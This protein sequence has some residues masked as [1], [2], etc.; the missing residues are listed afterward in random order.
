MRPPS[1]SRVL[2]VAK[3]EARTDADPETVTDL[4]RLWGACRRPRVPQGADAGTA[5][6]EPGVAS[7]DRPGLAVVQLQL[8]PP[9]GDDTERVARLRRDHRAA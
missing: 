3:P 8:H 1:F 6:P 9:A 7:E 4:A 2:S 5:E